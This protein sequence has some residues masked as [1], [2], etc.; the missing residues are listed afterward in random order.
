MYNLKALYCSWVTYF[1]TY[2][3]MHVH[4]RVVGLVYLSELLF[5][6]DN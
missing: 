4:A 1:S 5:L 2:M 6:T 3:D